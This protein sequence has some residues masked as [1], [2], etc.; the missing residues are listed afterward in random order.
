MKTRILVKLPNGN[1]VHPRHVTCIE[2]KHYPANPHNS[3]TLVWVRKDAGYGT[4]TFSFKGDR[5][6]ELAAIINQE[7]TTESTP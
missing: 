6:D 2:Y 7:T 1:F 4:G 5:R 3:A